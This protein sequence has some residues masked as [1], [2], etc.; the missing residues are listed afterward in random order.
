MMS[1]SITYNPKVNLF[2]RIWDHAAIGLKNHIGDRTHTPRNLIEKAGDGI[3]WTT[4]L[5][6]RAVKSM[7]KALQDPR[8]ATIAL[9]ALALFTVSLVFYPTLTIAAT[10]AAYTATI[11][12]ITKVPFWAAKFTTYILICSS[13]VGA[14]LR[15]G[16]RFHNAELMKEFYDFP[17]EYEGNPAHLSVK[18]IAKLQ[19]ASK[20]IESLDFV[21]PSLNDT[22]EVI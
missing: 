17:K 18:E 22:H 1:V 16:G 13:I 7:G 2:N 10:K 5:L 20:I 8:I 9:T 6:P 21:Q 3:L 11:L 4:G 14:G 15:A 19:N 12:A